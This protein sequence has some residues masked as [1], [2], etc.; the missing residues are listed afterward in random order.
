MEE[1][2]VDTELVILE[3]IYDAGLKPVP[4][5]Q[6]DLAHVAGASLGMTNVI[7]KRLAKKGLITIR[8]LNSRNIHYA[9]TPDGVNEIARRSYRYFKRTIRNVAFYRDQVD[10]AVA[11]AKRRGSSA[12]LLI[13]FSDLEFIVEH[14]CARHGLSFLKVAEGGTAAP[15]LA[16]GVFPVY[17]EGIQPYRPTPDPAA[18]LYLSRILT[19]RGTES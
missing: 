7:L 12:V 19:G 10:S 8:K 4:L 6:R 2:Y 11:G 1:E 5:R 14:A 9:V 16:S 17:A 18:G 13:G 15:V 3:N